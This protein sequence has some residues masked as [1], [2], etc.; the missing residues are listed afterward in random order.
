[1]KTLAVLAAGFLLVLLGTCIFFSNEAAVSL[2]FGPIWFLG[3]VLPRVTADR[4]SV[5]V[6]CVAVVLFTLGVHGLFRSRRGAASPDG[7]PPRR[8]RFRWSLAVTLVVFLLFAAGVSMVAAVHQAVWLLTAEG[9][10]YGETVGGD[11]FRTGTGSKNNL[12][13]MAFGMTFYAENYLGFPAGG[14][15]TPGGDMRHSWQTAV[16]PFML[17]YSTKNIDFTRPWNHPVNQKVFKSVL[18]EFI[19]PAMPV[20]SLTDEEGYGLSHYAVNSHVLGPNRAMKPQEITNGTANTLLIGEVNAE[21]KPW[22]HPVGWR[23]PLRGVN[24]SPHGFG[25]APRAGGANF[26][27]ADG[28]VRFVSERISPEVLRGL[29]LPRGPE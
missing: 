14:T 12:Q 28:S 26:A 11:P 19:N 1:M 27:M 8:W 10:L 2:L 16:L 4:P 18:A 21:F 25:G 20:P 3:R 5:V 15:F 24:R 6:G 9:P 22:G 7:Q 17:S 23:D 29:S 13:Q